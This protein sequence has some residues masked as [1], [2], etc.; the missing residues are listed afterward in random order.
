MSV[1]SSHHTVWIQCEGAEPHPERYA[2]DGDR[3]VAFGDGAL[4]HVPDGS[5][6]TASVHEIAGGPV[7]ASFG[8]RVRA[9]D[10]VAIDRQ[11]LLSLLD[12]VSLGRDAVEMERSID[13]HAHRRVLVLEPVGPTP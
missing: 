8:A 9:S 6:V 1:L 4:A 12:H 10:G 2:L 13:H 11:A 5:T 7:V 3:L